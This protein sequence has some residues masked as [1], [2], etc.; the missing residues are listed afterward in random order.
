MMAAGV[1]AI[2]AGFS[3]L[4]KLASDPSYLASLWFASQYHRDPTGATFKLAA[5]L[6]PMLLG[7]VMA[8]V[9]R[10]PQIG[11]WL[12]GWGLNPDEPKP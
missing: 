1:A 2:L 10:A 3:A 5:A 6:I 9:G 8:A 7:G 11:G 12:N 4:L